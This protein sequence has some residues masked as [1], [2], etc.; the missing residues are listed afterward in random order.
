MAYIYSGL[1]VLNRYRILNLAGFRKV[2]RKYERVTKIPV[3][4]AYMEQ[5]VE[6]STFASGAVVAAMLKETERH[7]AM[8]FERGDRKKAR[9]NLRV[10][11]S[12]KTHHFSTFRSGLWLGLAIPAIA[13]GSYLSFQ[14]H[15]RG[16]LPSWDILLYIYSILTV[17]ILL[18]LLIGVNILVWTRKRINYAFIFELNPRSRLDHHEYFELPSLLLCTLAYAFWF[19]LARIG[20]PML[21]PLIWLALTLVVILNPIRSFMWGPARWWTI[22]NVAK[23]GACG[24]RDVRFTDVWLGDQCCS[25]VYSL[26]NLYFVGCFYTR[27]ANYVSTYDP[28][29]QEA[30]STCSVTQNWTW[31]YLLSMLPFMVRFMQSLRRYRDSKN[32]IHLINAGKYTIAIIYYLCYFYWKHQGSPHTGKSYILWCFTAAVNSIYGC[33]W[34]F[35]M[36]WSVCRPHARYPLLRQELVYKSH[37]PVRSLVPTS[38]MPLTMSRS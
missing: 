24:T 29:V 20:P 3:L 35:L 36:D 12:S 2:L 23:L 14:E 25:L 19:S 1:E 6:P 17:P 11:P 31:Y 22:K 4:E 18:S 9:G 28:Q 7:F 37:I 13:G 33:A 32:F 8:R 16:S 21:W 30:W 15:T 5:K 27:F 26:S 10:G 38:L 34:D